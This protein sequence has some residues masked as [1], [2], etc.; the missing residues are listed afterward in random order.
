MFLGLF[1]YFYNKHSLSQQVIDCILNF[2]SFSSQKA[3]GMSWSDLY[4]V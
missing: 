2:S 4:S 3:Q 1:V